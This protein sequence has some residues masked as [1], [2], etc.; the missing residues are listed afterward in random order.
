MPIWNSSGALNALTNPLPS[1]L[2]GT[3]WVMGGIESFYINGC[4]NPAN[5]PSNYSYVASSTNSLTIWNRFPSQNGYTVTVNPTSL[6][7]NPN[8]Y[9]ACPL[10][11]YPGATEG[12]P[13]PGFY[14]GA[15]EYTTINDPSSAHCH[16]L[17]GM[18]HVI[19]GAP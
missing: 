8:G 3:Q 10:N 1:D 9:A 18:R 11:I 16:P 6:N 15:I 7:S 12:T 19:R 4:E 2:D 13:D 14:S 17:H 5:W